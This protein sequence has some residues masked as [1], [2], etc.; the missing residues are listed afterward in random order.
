MS[1]RAYKKLV[2]YIAMHGLVEGDR[3]PPQRDLRVEL[4]LTNDALGNAMGV[5]AA[6]G[7]IT[8]RQR[9]GTVIRDTR[10]VQPVPWSV[11][12][13]ASPAP[14]TGA[15]S[16]FAQLISRLLSSLSNRD[17]QCS[18]YYR[19]VERHPARLIDF[20]F[21]TD[22]VLADELDGVI[23]LTDL[24]LD[25]WNSLLLCGVPV[26]HAH[27]WEE[28]PCGVIDDKASVCQ[29]AI[30]QFAR[31]G[32]TK[33][34]I[35]SNLRID[36][37]KTRAWQGVVDAAANTRYALSD[38]E[39][40]FSRAGIESGGKIAGELMVRPKD[41]RPDGVIVLDDYTALG[42]ADALHSQNSYRPA[43]AVLAAKQLPLRYPLPVIPFEIDI[44]VLATRAADMLIRRMNNPA[45]PQELVHMPIG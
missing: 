2:Q 44:D 7:V 26:C 18:T 14:A 41:D 8:R 36:G 23:L 34:A 25:D 11:G 27:Y 30:R 15:G 28:A 33:I 13:A 31:M 21:L 43:I 35:V 40:I 20:A 17:C 1:R 16:F 42:L 6:R 5:L 10:A 45:L 9:A 12:L 32:V 3:F 24:H 39:W 22:K 4:R 37:E 38:V 29:L 19:Q